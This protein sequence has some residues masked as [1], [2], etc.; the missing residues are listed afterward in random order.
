[1]YARRVPSNTAVDATPHDWRARAGRARPAS[2]KRPDP[3]AFF[4]GRGMLHWRRAQPTEIGRPTLFGGLKTAQRL[5]GALTRVDQPRRPCPSSNMPCLLGI[6][7]PYDVVLQ[8]ACAG[9]G[10]RGG[11]FG[12]L[13]LRETRD[14]GTRKRTAKPLLPGEIMAGYVESAVQRRP[15]E[16]EEERGDAGKSSDHQG[17]GLVSCHFLL[18]IFSAAFLGILVSRGELLASQPASQQAIS[19]VGKYGGP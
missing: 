9:R 10:G 7:A 11:P 13:S 14:P 16:E 8:Q 2:H 18:Y 1:M 6:Y 12:S 17:R 19:H 4:R 5:G 15:K 3:V